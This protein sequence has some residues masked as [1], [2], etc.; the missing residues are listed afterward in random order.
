MSE[1]EQEG[2]EVE[3]PDETGD[4]EDGDETETGDADEQDEID[5]ADDPGP[6][7]EPESEAVMEEI[8]KKLDALTKTVATRISTI[9]GEHALD[10]EVC[11]LCSYWNTPGW[12][13]SGQLPEEL[14]E[15]LAHVIGQHAQSEYVPDSH[16]AM[17]AKC[18]GLGSVLSGSKAMGQQLLPCFE[19]EARGWMPTDDARTKGLGSRLNGPVSTGGDGSVEDHAMQPTVT[20][21]T[22]E[23]RAL[24]AQ[25]YVVIPPMVGV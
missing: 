11:D 23:I 17:C 21:D 18:N 2:A 15:Q 12:R 9:L 13:K 6:V 5:P 7:P 3:Q 20:A 1:T 22:P 25:G 16:S 24:K 14:Q 4:T 8:G 19:C 10:F